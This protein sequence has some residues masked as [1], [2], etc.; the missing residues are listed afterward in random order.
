MWRAFV[1]LLSAAW[2]SRFVQNLRSAAIP[3]SAVDFGRPDMLDEPGNPGLRMQAN[4]GSSNDAFPRHTYMATGGP[5]TPAGPG[6]N[7]RSGRGRVRTAL[8]LRIKWT[9]N[10]SL[11]DNLSTG[12]LGPYR[13]GAGQSHILEANR[14]GT[15]PKNWPGRPKNCPGR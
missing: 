5:Q 14:P 9:R 11:I 7:R 3:G 10:Q 1:G 13:G 12:V 4:K 6:R 8:H 2:I 15:A